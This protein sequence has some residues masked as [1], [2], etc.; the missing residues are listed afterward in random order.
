MKLSKNRFMGQLKIWN[1]MKIIIILILLSLAVSLLYSNNDVEA[2]KI[3]QVMQTDH[4]PT[5]DGGYD[6]LLVYLATNLIYPAIYS[7]ANIQGKIICRFIVAE[8]GAILDVRIIQGLDK[9]LDEEVIRVVR[10]M[11]KWQP[12]RRKG[13]AVNVEYFLPVLL[14]IK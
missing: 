13:K 8:D 10:S 3:Y 5:F 12:G 11:P 4:M 1:S 2:N 9:F 14:R 7:D 6:S